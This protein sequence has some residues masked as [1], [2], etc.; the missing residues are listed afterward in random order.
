MYIVY[1]YNR[2]RRR[3]LLVDVAVAV[4]VVVIYV[5]VV[6]VVSVVEVCAVVDGGGGGGEGGS[7]SG[8]IYLYTLY[9]R[10]QIGRRR[11]RRI[12]PLNSGPPPNEPTLYIT[13][14]PASIWTVYAHRSSL[15]RCPFIVIFTNII[16]SPEVFSSLGTHSFFPVFRSTAIPYSIYF[17][18]K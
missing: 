11:R 18:N 5:V 7:G 17:L 14:L 2:R 6:V 1:L 10:Y 12:S 13:Q 3:W 4:S 16:S 9:N 8:C 15:A